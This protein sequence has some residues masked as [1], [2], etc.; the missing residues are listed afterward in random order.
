MKHFL[1]FALCSSL[2]ALT[3]CVTIPM[4]QERSA[5]ADTLAAARHWTRTTIATD[6]FDLAAWL[7]DKIVPAPD[8]TI[9]IEGDGLAWLSSDTPSADPTP[10]TPVGL[11]LAL[12]HPGGNAAYLARPCQYLAAP[13][14]AQRHWTNQRFAPEVIA[15]TNQAVDT[16]KQRFGANRLNLVG[17]SGGGAIATLLAERR[18]DVVRLVTV[19]GNLDHRAWTAYHRISPLTGS[20]NPADDKAAL[21]RIPQWHFVGE[22]DSVVPPVL[23]QAFAA[24]MPSARVKTMTSYDHRCCWAE[25]WPNIWMDIH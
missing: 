3:A 22:R 21:A 14:C 4:L 2:L 20:L 18:S 23:A 6:A 7:P 13:R 16:L 25:N 12:A 15:A 19:A 11:Q 10:V 9:Y 1:A 8:L 24:G 5:S 17:Y